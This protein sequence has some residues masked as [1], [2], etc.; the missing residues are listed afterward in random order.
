VVIS[1]LAT[2]VARRKFRAF[3]DLTVMRFDE[4]VALYRIV[5]EKEAFH[6]SQSG[7]VTGGTY[8]FKAERHFGASWGADISEVIKWGNNQRG[9]RLGSKLFLIKLDAFDHSF[10]HLEPLLEPPFD[11]QGDKEQ[12]A[13]FH[14]GSCNTSVGCSIINVPAADCE[15]YEV[16]EQGQITRLPLSKLK[17]KASYTPGETEPVDRGD[18]PLKPRQKFQIEKGSNKLGVVPNSTGWVERVYSYEKDRRVFVVLRFTYGRKL[19]GQRE[20]KPL[21][22]YAPHKNGLGKTPIRLRDSQGNAIL[23][24]KT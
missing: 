4:A 20:D 18:L 11:P 9:K 19:K 12:P 23:I 8:S 16:D 10:A 7:K 14:T 3:P 6:I 21:T 5:D 2:E 17:E 24:R 13:V 1:K 22:L 15:F